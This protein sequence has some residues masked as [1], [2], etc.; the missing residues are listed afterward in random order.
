MTEWMDVLPRA[1]DLLALSLAGIGISAC[2]RLKSFIS[3]FGVFAS[4]TASALRMCHHRKRVRFS[5]RVSKRSR[6]TAIL[7]NLRQSRNF[8]T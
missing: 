1:S 3:I 8:Y 6:R 7:V 5:V 4:A 2:Y